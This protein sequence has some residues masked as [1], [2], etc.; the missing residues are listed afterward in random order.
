MI[1]KKER[2]RLRA[3]DR[4]A[5]PDWIQAVHVEE[6]RAIV[7][8]HTTRESLLAVDADGMAIFD[9]PADAAV[10]CAARNALVP[11]L[12]ALDA[13]ERCVVVSTD[14][15]VSGGAWVRIPPGGSFIPA[16]GAARCF[17]VEGSIRVDG[18]PDDDAP[19]ALNFEPT[20]APS[21]RAG[22]RGALLLHITSPQA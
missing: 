14:M 9:R 4:E 12:D 8:I 16:P 3:L 21:F 7:S 18:A 15:A 20:A 5:T 19:A 1:S 11:L 22:H 13:A 2:D 17:V 10:A 6:P